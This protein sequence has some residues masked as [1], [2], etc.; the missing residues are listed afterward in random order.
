MNHARTLAAIA[1][2]LLALLLVSSCGGPVERGAEAMPIPV[3]AP[4]AIP[5][6]PPEPVRDGIFVL[7]DG[8]TL[9][10]ALGT[11]GVPATEIDRLSRDARSVYDLA[12]LRSGNAIHFRLTDDGTGVD[13]LRYDIDPENYVEAQR[14]AEGFAVRK[15]VVPFTASRETLR[16]TVRTCLFC[17]AEKENWDLGVLSQLAEEVLAWDVDFDSDVQP[18]DTFTALV[19]RKT[20]ETGVV[21]YGRVLAATASVG[22]ETISAVWYE[23]GKDGAY[24]APTGKAMKKS[25]LRTPLKFRRVSSGFSYRRVHPISRRV[26]PHLGVDFAAPSGTPVRAAADGVVAFAG[27]R[28]GFGNFI[29]IRHA[30]GY[31][32]WYAHLNGI[33]RG[34]RSGARV[35]QGQL[36]GTVGATGIATGPH[37]DYRMKQGGRF[38]NPMAQ[39][40]LPGAPIPKAKKEAFRAEADRLLAALAPPPIAASTALAK[41]P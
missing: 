6:A 12:R 31:E 40:F 41:A 13:T 9:A 32:T 34:A 28:R 19:E 37:L 1:F 38:V 11:L 36:I 4:E 10:T 8:D 30:S 21:R 24:Y 33:A 35:R 22:G 27:K 20:L 26:R 15:A 29:Q 17:E 16:M 2:F 18:G 3:A 14:T 25:F 39:R 7:A 5:P 23:T